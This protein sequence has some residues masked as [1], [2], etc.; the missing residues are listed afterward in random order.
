MEEVL[1]QLPD[2]QDKSASNFSMLRLFGRVCMCV[3]SSVS[4][5]V[6]VE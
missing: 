3:F 1:Q 5:S 6:Y 4:T 2:A